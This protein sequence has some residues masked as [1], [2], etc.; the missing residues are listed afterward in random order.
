MSVIDS[1]YPQFVD[2]FL[3]VVVVIVTELQKIIANNN[4]F[5]CL[6][7]LSIRKIACWWGRGGGAPIMLVLKTHQ[8]FF[9][10]HCLVV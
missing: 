9:D 10:H 3:V 2:F 8:I 1:S 7:M 6:T 4:V 5:I